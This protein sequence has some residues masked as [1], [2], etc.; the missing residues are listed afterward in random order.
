MQIRIFGGFMEESVQTFG[1][2]LKTLRKQRK[3]TQKMLAE[4]ICAQSLISRVENDE[5]LPNALVL[6]QI[7]QR[8]EVTMDQLMLSQVEEITELNRKFDEIHTHFIQTNYEKVYTLIHDENFINQLQLEVDLQRYYY[9]LGSCQYY[10]KNQ[11]QFAIE[12]L[13]R[14]ILYTYG[15]NKSNI[16]TIEI[17]MISCLGRVYGESG[18]LEEAL[19]CTRYC[20][21]CLKEM[22]N[23]RKTFELVKV[24]YNYADILFQLKEL[25][26][27]LEV[28]EEGFL[29]GQQFS[30]YYYLKELFLLKGLILQKKEKMLEASEYFELAEMIKKIENG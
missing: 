29:L 3:L 27:A 22:P 13:K 19:K 9:Y 26:L 7:C 23:E 18:Q 10:A 8:L 28:I 15:Q 4:G 14:G 20:Y 12:S 30:S 6:Q 25:D 11:N 17:Q 5:E 24:A 16:S 21:N 2:T 1:Q